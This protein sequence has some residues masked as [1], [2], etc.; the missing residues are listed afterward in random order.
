[1]NIISKSLVH[2][3]VHCLANSVVELFRVRCIRSISELLLRNSETGAAFT[4]EDLCLSVL[5]A[6]THDVGNISIP[7]VIS[8][9]KAPNAGRI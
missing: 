7:D 2:F 5:G 1:M 8:R 3:V 4:E 9:K 6:I